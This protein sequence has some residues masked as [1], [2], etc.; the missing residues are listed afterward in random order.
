[1]N[2]K[3]TS[4][5]LLSSRE[6][7]ML[8]QAE[9]AEIIGNVSLR[10]WRYWEFGERSIPD[11]VQARM[12]ELLKARNEILSHTESL[13]YEK[14]EKLGD[15]FKIAILLYIT[16]DD[17]NGSKVE[18]NI[19]NSVAKFIYGRYCEHVNL[20][21]FNAESFNAW[22]LENGKEDSQETRSEWATLQ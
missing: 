19:V 6:V 17:F 1:M 3:M 16:P 10:C 2:K 22:C 8:S 18:F 15:N 9:C 20:I 12:Y 13:I 14:I 21:S 11:Y 7:L 5:E 4:V